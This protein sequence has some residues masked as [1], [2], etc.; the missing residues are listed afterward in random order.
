[1][2]FYYLIIFYV[3]FILLNVFNKYFHFNI[4]YVNLSINVNIIF[5]LS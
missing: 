3:I 1:M 2:K 4:N 5:I